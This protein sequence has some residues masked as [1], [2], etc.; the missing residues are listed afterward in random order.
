MY[1]ENGN[2]KLKYYFKKLDSKKIFNGKYETFYKDGKKEFIKWYKNGILEGRLLYWDKVGKFK[3]YESYK[4]GK[5][6]GYSFKINGKNYTK[7]LYKDDVLLE[8]T[9]YINKKFYKGNNILYDDNGNIMNIQKELKYNFKKIPEVKDYELYFE[10]IEYYNYDNKQIKKKAYYKK[11]IKTSTYRVNILS[12]KNNRSNNKKFIGTSERKIWHGK[13][14]TYYE[15]GNLKSEIWFKDGL[16]HGTSIYWSKKGKFL[17][18]DH[19]NNDKLNGISIYFN[20]INNH[21]VEKLYVND[22]LKKITRVY[23][24]EFY[25]KCQKNILTCKST[26][27]FSSCYCGD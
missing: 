6:T 7:Y 3:L 9:T 4:N 27:D 10:D 20:G 21:K 25:K 13:E 1:Y 16:L 26:F 5:K 23:S 24:S 14:E 8:E 18:I 19:Y 2:I 15:N 12:P 11:I 22:T 17:G